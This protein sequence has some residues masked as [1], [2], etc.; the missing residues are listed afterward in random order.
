MNAIL[1]SSSEIYGS[2]YL[3]YLLPELEKLY[4]DIHTILFIPFARPGGQPHDE[5]TEKARKGLKQLGKKVIGLHE[6]EDYQTAI[7]TAE[8]IFVGGGNTFLLVTKLYKYD[9][10]EVLREAIR[11]GTPYL[12]TSAG[13]NICGLTMQTTNDM[14]IVHPQSFDTLGIVPFNFNV[15]YRD[16]EPNSKHRGETRETRIQEFQRIHPVTVIGLREGSWLRIT[17][18]DIVLCGNLTAR[19]FDPRKIPFEMDPQT[20]LLNVKR[21]K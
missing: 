4:K 8:G 11:K 15:H 9:L 13:S 1:A 17:K 3:A 5:Y 6:T 14:P 16:P 12:G 21:E 19:V 18:K 2:D 7:K 20:S 10:I